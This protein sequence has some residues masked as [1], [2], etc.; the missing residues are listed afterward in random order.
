M[1]EEFLRK[2]VAEGFAIDT[3]YDIGANRGDWS[4]NLKKVLPLSQFILFEANSMHNQSLISTGFPCFNAVLSSPHNDYVDF[5]KVNGFNGTGDSYYQE[6]TTYYDG[7]NLATQLPC[8]TLDNLVY[9]NNLPI[10][11]LI[12]L[13]TQGSELDILS[14]ASFLDQVDMIYTEC[15]IVCY[16]KGAPNMQD[17]LN[18]F[19]S[20]KFV[21]IDIFEKHY[22][23]KILVQVDMLFVKHETKEK[24]MGTTERLKPFA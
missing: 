16:N 18:F 12:K 14:G 15:P 23:D 7:E 8:T 3:I 19:K 10:P 4:L 13:D 9:T 5:Y 1:L 6:N 22:S 17:Y 21:P 11:N 20:R 2:I 24:L